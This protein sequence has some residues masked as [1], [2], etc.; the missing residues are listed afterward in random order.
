MERKL[1]KNIRKKKT[2]AWKKIMTW[3][4]SNELYSKKGNQSVKKWNE[5]KNN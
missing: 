2:K 5:M 3:K 1:M 4:Q